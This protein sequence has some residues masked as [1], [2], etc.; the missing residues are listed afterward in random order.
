[1]VHLD[2]EEAL[3]AM[4]YCGLPVGETSQMLRPTRRRKVDK[5]KGR[6]VRETYVCLVAGPEGGGKEA[7]LNCFVERT[8]EEAERDEEGGQ[9]AANIVGPLPV[10]PRPSLHAAHRLKSPFFFFFRNKK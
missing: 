8:F 2:P 3:A 5:K 6:N 1:M 7:M 4:V 9:Y 10:N